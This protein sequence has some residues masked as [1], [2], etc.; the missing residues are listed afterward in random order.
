[1]AR[2]GEVL[3]EYGVV[4]FEMLQEQDFS[5]WAIK[6]NQRMPWSPLGPLSAILIFHIFYLLLKDAFK[7]IFL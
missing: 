2:K 5:E 6:Y 1:M 4:P 7:N 3:L